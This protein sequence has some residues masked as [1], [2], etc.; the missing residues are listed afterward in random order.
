MD[1]LS[2]YIEIAEMNTS[3]NSAIVIGKLKRI[4]ARHS[5]CLEMTSY[6][7]PPFNSKDFASFKKEYAWVES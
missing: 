7:G 2:Q 6:N 1:Y 5:M 3:S 4:F